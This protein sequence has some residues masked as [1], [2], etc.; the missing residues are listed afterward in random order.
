[1]NIQPKF[2][3][4]CTGLSTY[5]RSLW[6]LKLSVYWQKVAVSDRNVRVEVSAAEHKSKLHGEPH[7]AAAVRQAGRRWKLQRLRHEWEAVTSGSREDSSSSSYSRSGGRGEN[8]AA[9]SRSVNLGWLVLSMIR[10]C[11]AATCHKPT[12]AQQQR[13]VAIKLTYALETAETARR[14][15]QI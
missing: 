2:A 8:R 10:R 1:M 6:I 15:L 5:V 7:K 14:K 3:S 13:M 9:A 11:E 12:I 4:T